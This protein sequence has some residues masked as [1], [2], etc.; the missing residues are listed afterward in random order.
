MPTNKTLDIANDPN[1][2]LVVSSI[3]ADRHG[4]SLIPSIKAGKDVYVEWPIEANYAKSKELTDLVK[5][6]GVRNVVGIQ[7]GYTPLHTKIRALTERGGIGRLES[8]TVLQTTEYSGFTVP[9]HLYHQLD[10][11]NGSNPVTVS[12]PHSLEIITEGKS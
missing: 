2:D 6:R 12:F 8:S 5:A 1:I 9:N 3:R 11:S 4:G 10:K 7:G